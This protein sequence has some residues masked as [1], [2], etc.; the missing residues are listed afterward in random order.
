MISKR[1][2]NFT[3]RYLY[4]DEARHLFEYCGYDIEE[5]AGDYDGSP[6]NRDSNE[7]IWSLVLR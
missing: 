2:A 5:I 6:Y 1:Y 7:T 4:T 3:L